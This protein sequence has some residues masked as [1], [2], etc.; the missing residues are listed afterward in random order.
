MR[1]LTA[2]PEMSLEEAYQLQEQWAKDANKVVYIILDKSL[3]GGVLEEKG[4]GS[5]LGM[6]GDVDFFISEEE[7]EETKK[8]KIIAEIN[9]M[10]ADPQNRS[11]GFARE[12]LFLSLDHIIKHKAVDTF[13]AKIADTNL[14]SIQFFTKT[15]GFQEIS[16][17]AAFGEITYTLPVTTSLQ[18]KLASLLL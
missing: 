3:V 12:A 1:E 6:V 17:S 5:S 2:T 11:K 8:T 13:V 18:E 7:D 4:K 10:I 15:L 9:V 16:R 14:P